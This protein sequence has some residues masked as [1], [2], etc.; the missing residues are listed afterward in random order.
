MAQ[1]SAVE[2][3]FV[4]VRRVGGWLLVAT[5]AL[6]VYGSLFPFR[7]GPSDPAL[8]RTLL[9]LSWRYAG[10]GDV[11][12]NLLLY[13]PFGMS[14]ALVLPARTRRPLA[15]VAIL[16]TG[17]L[18][19]LCIEA[20]QSLTP[21]RVSSLPDVLLNGI[22]TLAGAVVGLVVGE[23]ASL[24]ISGFGDDENAAMPFVLLILW[25]GFRLAPFVPTIDWQKYKDA[26]KPVLLEPRVG[27]LGVFSYLVGWLIV[28]QAVRGIW[29]GTQAWIVFLV[30]AAIVLLG[31][32]VVVNRVVS[33]S[34]VLAIALCLVLVPVSARVPDPRRA[35][36]LAALACATIIVQG[37]EPFTFGSAKAFS[38]V[39]FRNSITGGFE[40]GYTSL[41]EKAF[42]YAS[43]LWLL[44]RT[45]ARL[46]TATLAVAAL[47]AAIEIVQIWVPGR[48]PEITDPL[49]A[50]VLA[51]L[52][53]VLA[54]ARQAPAT[55]SRARSA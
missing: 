44:T 9:Q 33:A 10:R 19:S 38:W 52:M 5:A 4:D 27:A 31:G 25:L 29:R 35:F 34:E 23:R 42:W 50:L 18:L 55:A 54:G 48:S 6:I 13:A 47:L 11:V 14:L 22:G 43:L 39:P 37:L 28:A 20:V 41:F 1:R 45:G 8:G 15:L 46:A 17:V 2:P 7:F 16:A 26:L 21:T 49:L 24:R 51:W 40:T 12:A 32:V 36:A 30:L 3:S 53:Y